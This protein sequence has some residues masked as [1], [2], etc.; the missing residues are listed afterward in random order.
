MKMA[1]IVNHLW[2]DNIHFGSNQ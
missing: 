2:S 1:D